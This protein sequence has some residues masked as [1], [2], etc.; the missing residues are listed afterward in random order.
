MRLFT[1]FKALT[2]AANCLPAPDIKPRPRT[3]EARK[4]PLSNITH[5]EFTITTPSDGTISRRRSMK[6]ADAIESEE[7]E[8]K[9]PL[10][11]ADYI[12]TTPDPSPTA[13]AFTFSVKPPNQHN[14]YFP[15]A[16][17]LKRKRKSEL[18]DI[19]RRVKSVKLTVNTKMLMDLF[20]EHENDMRRW[21]IRNPAIEAEPLRND[22][23][24]ATSA[25]AIRRCGEVMQSRRAS[26]AFGAF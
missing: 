11:H 7:T 12:E 22:L 10:L 17:S 4:R 3:Q 25:D 13:T 14:P 24:V 18:G 16:R 2:E 1:H 23:D 21:Q 5:E 26:L 8:E 20:D 15:P 9:H 6:C 19:V